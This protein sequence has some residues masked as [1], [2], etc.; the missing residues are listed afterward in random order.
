MYALSDFVLPIFEP[1]AGGL[2]TLLFPYGGLLRTGEWAVLY[3]LL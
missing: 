2:Y 1:R 3:L